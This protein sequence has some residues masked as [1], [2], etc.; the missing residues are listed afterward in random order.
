VHAR[1]FVRNVTSGAELHCWKCGGKLAGVPLPIGRLEE[2]PTCHA[3]LHVCRMCEFYDPR[4][5]RS[6]R[7]PIAE[8]VTDKERSNF[9]GYFRARSGTFAA[10]GSAEAVRARARLDALF[11]LG[12]EDSSSSDPNGAR[13]RLETLFGSDKGGEKS[14]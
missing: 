5:A 7:E 11:S 14:R 6:C 8:E 2:C 3:D 1:V 12:G 4:V 10:Q 13:D 9:C